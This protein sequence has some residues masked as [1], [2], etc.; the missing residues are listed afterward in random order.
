MPSRNTR[1]QRR[2]DQGGRFGHRRG[3][4]YLEETI[5]EVELERARTKTIKDKT[6]QACGL[7]DVKDQP[8]GACIANSR[9]SPGPVVDGEAEATGCERRKGEGAD[10]P[11]SEIERGTRRRQGKSAHARRGDGAFAEIAF[12][13]RAPGQSHGRG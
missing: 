12:G 13:E 5:A 2:Y 7:G 8:V 3:R 6:V 11:G 1:R 10:G 9:E 4:H